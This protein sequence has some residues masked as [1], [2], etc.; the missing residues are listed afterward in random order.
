MKNLVRPKQME[1]LL[2]IYP[3]LVAMQK[4]LK[5]EFQDIN[6]R[7]SIDDDDGYEYIYSHTVKRDVVNLPSGYTGVVT[8]KTGNIAST[9]KKA[10][11]K[12]LKQ[13]I[14]DIS[15]D[16]LNITTIVEK[17]DVGM[18]SLYGR[19]KK[20]ISQL[21][22]DQMSWKQIAKQN[23]VSERTAQTERNKALEKLIRVSMITLNMYGRII[24]KFKE[25]KDRGE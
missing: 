14:K 20:I 8:D 3:E 12:E 6:A 2:I 16:L 17:L 18:A 9:Y 25:L 24:K 10:I 11:K 19:R 21:Y 1:E 22:W 15:E 4:S 7:Q 5:I 23:F 13:A